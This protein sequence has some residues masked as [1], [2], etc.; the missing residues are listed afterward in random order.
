MKLNDM[1]EVVVKEADAQGRISIPIQW[2]KG[3]KSRKLVLIRRENR[4]EII[5]IEFTRPSELFDS[6]TISEDVDFVD[7]HSVKKALL[8][9]REH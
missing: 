9:L 3:W 5:P 6:I 4:V 7:S 8:E 2:R 1:V